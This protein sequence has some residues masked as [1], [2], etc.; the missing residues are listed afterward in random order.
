MDVAADR[1]L[2]VP[3]DVTDHGQV[4]AAVAAAEDAFGGID[5][6][7]DDVGHIR[8]RVQRH[9]DPDLALGG[10]GQEASALRVRNVL[11]RVEVRL[12]VHDQGVRGPCGLRDWKV[13]NRRAGVPE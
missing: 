8:A 10:G 4:T 12:D 13:V 3:L 11:S 1:A 6:L 2:A 9:L 5:V 7:V